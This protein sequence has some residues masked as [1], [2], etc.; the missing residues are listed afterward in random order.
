MAEFVAIDVAE[1]IERGLEYT[2]K[3]GR[4]GFRVQERSN[5]FLGLVGSV[6]FA[7]SLGL[8][9]IGRAGDPRNALDRWLEVSNRSAAG[10]FEAL[11][12]LLG[13]SV[14]LA[15]LVELNHF[16][17]LTAREIARDLRTGSLGLF[18]GPRTLPTAPFRAVAHYPKRD[19]W[20]SYHPASV[21]A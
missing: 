4:D 5:A 12:N 3:T 18:L 16:N 14:A 11:A 7:G 20:V 6:Y 9:L 13:I 2:T 10:K 8:A 19:S 15:R 1:L 21:G 17:G